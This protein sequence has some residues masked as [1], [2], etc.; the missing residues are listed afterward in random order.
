MRTT[1]KRERVRD[2]G[3]EEPWRVF[4]LEPSLDH[5]SNILTLLY[6]VSS[7]WF[8][9]PVI[10]VC[11]GIFDRTSPPRTLTS[12]PARSRSI[13]YYWT[14]VPIFVGGEPSVTK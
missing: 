11:D 13:R 14:P 4:T 3:V 5:M 6:Q 10:V 12:N 7:R 2:I 8:C 9:G 1:E